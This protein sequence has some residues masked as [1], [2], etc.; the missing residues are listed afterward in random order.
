MVLS[1]LS[2]SSAASYA[3]THLNEYTAAVIVFCQGHYF[4]FSCQTTDKGG[5]ISLRSRLPF[6]RVLANEHAWSCADRCPVSIVSGCHDAVPFVRLGALSLGV[7]ARGVGSAGRLFRRAGATV[8][9]AL[10]R[11]LLLYRVTKCISQSICLAS[12]QHVKRP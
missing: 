5:P 11:V 9:T 2:S 10:E 6:S 8:K 12:I 3:C 1:L 4:S 7:C